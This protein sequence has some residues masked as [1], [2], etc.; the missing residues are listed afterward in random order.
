ML[1][2][3]KTSFLPTVQGGER[4][5]TQT[6]NNTKVI[7][8]NKIYAEVLSSLKFWR[9]NKSKDGISIYVQDWCCCLKHNM[10]VKFYCMYM[11]H[12]SNE[13]D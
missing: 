7:Y 11:N 12:P 8:P 6:C 3:N 4:I 5:T 10:D 1:Y 2:K 13:Y 9:L